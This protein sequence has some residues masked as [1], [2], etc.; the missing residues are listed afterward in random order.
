MPASLIIEL[1]S[2]SFSGVDNMRKKSKWQNSWSSNLFLLPAAVIY[3]SVIVLPALYTIIISLF[4]WNG[5]SEMEFVGFDNFINL[6]TKDDVFIISL[7]NNLLWLVLTIIVT[8][9]LALILAVILNKQFKGRTFFRGYFYFPCVIAPIAVAI[10]WRWIYNPNIGFINQFFQLIGLDYTQRWISD[11]KISIY[12]VFAAALWQAVGQP[13]ILFLAGLQTVPVD[14]LEAAT[15]DGAS[16]AKRFFMVTVP[17]MRDTFVIVIATLTV[18]AVRVYDIV[19][20]LTDGGPNNATQMLSTY[21]Y[22]QTFKYSNVG[23]GSAIAFIM[24]L[25]MVIVIVPYVMFTAKED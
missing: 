8:M 12:C 7:R 17:L 21:M 13:M 19:V 15:I 24:V 5:I 23:T 10:M 3:L 20:G 6:F 22:S 4:K 9:T 16:G 18:A 11:A 14:V 1:V 2:F 25:M